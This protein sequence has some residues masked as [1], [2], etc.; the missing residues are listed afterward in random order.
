MYVF[1]MY[2][3]VIYLFNSE[4][5]SISNLQDLNFFMV[6]VFFILN[7]FLDFLEKK[8]KIFDLIVYLQFS[9]F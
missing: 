7:K 8:N 5:I 2:F 9:I 6:H 4:I 3:I 1:K